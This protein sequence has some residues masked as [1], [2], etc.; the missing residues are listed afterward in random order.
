M[1]HMALCKGRHDIP[2]AVDGAIFATEINPLAVAEMES[3]ATE[4]VRGLDGL[5]LYVTGLSVA[6]V[7][8]INACHRENV[9]LTLMHYDRES[10]S[11]YPQEVC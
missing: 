5:T 3:Y 4:I 6:L 8:V 2:D 11:Y 10:G 9:M 1:K 7:A